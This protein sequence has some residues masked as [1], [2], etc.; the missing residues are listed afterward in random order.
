MSKKKIKFARAVAGLGVF[1]SLLAGCAVKLKYASK[2]LKQSRGKVCFHNNCFK[3]ELAATPE[4]RARGLMFKRDLPYQEG[5]LFLFDKEDRHSFWMKNTFVPLD[6]IWIN[7]DKR[8]VFIKKNAQP[9][10]GDLC[11]SISPDRKAMYVLELNSGVSDT[12]GLKAADKV[13]ISL[14]PQP[15]KNN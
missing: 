15:H 2:G 11:S 14:F 4:Q 5:M 1:L 6:I 10:R 13:T 8:V 7:K 3:V 9:C 12:I